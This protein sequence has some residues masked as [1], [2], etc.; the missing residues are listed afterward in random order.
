MAIVDNKVVGDKVVKI[1]SAAGEPKYK[2]IKSYLLRRISSGQFTSGFPLPS[3][4]TLANSAGIARNTVRQAL[5]ELEKEGVLQ[6]LP[7][8]GT[9]VVG[10]R[11]Q[12][13][14]EGVAIFSII[15]PELR[16]N[17]YP[18]LIRG[19]NSGA[20]KTH[21]QIMVCNTDYN[22]KEQADNILQILHKKVAGVAIVPTIS[23]LTPSYHIQILQE[24]NISVVFCIRRVAG[25]SA[26]LISWDFEECGQIAGRA[27]IERGH[28][29]IAYFADFKFSSTEA[30]E[31]GLRN[32]LV[33]NSLELPEDRVYFGDKLGK[34]DEVNKRKVLQ[35][36]LESKDRPTAVFC[37]DDNEAET[38]YLLSQEL[39][40]KVPEELSIVGAG[41][42]RRDGYMRERLASV[43]VDAFELGS[44]VANILNEM[45]TNELLIHNDRE[46]LMPLTLRVGQT[47]AKAPKM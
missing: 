6:R 17:I 29:R 18:S 32:V 3:E 10:S 20:S 4:S 23:P 12:K 30:Y 11:E 25:T 1:S 34:T 7:G 8:R 9:F 24:H 27:L 26:P 15:L 47:L 43:T 35:R 21:H 14:R 46:M 22:V 28:Q 39:G 41:E 13:I 16:R 42:V 2:Q 38:V 5:A 36:M 45:N 31:N 44:R 37:N 40:V 33:S 19:F